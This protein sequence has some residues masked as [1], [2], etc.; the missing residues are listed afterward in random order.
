MTFVT[1]SF[2]QLLE[3]GDA[4]NARELAAAG[5]VEQIAGGEVAFAGVGSPLTHAIGCGMTAPV[6]PGELDRIEQFYRDRGAP[7]ILDICPFTHPSLIDLTGRRGYRIVEFNNV[8]ARTIKPEDVIPPPELSIEVARPEDGLAWSRCLAQGFF[9]HDDASPDEIEIGAAL[10]RMNRARCLFALAD[11]E[12]AGGGAM[13]FDG[14]LAQFFADATLVRFRKRGVQR[15][16]ILERLSYAQAQ[17]AQYACAS[18][19]PG[20][21][22]QRNYERCGFRVAYTKLGIMREL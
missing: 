11:G 1:H 5:E 17:G 19:V 12:R 16:L 8:L 14:P 9:E 21:V 13:S 20:T 3:G 22:S 15:A 2:A 4:R 18:T 7:A 10:F 6:T